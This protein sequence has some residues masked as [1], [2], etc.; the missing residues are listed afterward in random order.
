MEELDQIIL[1]ILRQI[2]CNFPEDIDTIS[3]FQSEHFVFA[4]SVALRT[5]NAAYKLPKK[6]PDA[7]A[8]RFRICT[9]MANAIQQLGYTGEIG[10]ETFLYPNEKDMRALMSF[11]VNK[12]PKVEEEH[13]EEM[14]GQSAMVTKKIVASLQG[15][16]SQHWKPFSV[17]KTQVHYHA[18]P[19][20][21]PVKTTNTDTQHYFKHYLPVINVQV[22]HNNQY[23]P[24]I[25]QTH[26]AEVSLINERQA[27]WDQEGVEGRSKEAILARKQMLAKKIAE[28]ISDAAKKAASDLAASAAFGGAASAATSLGYSNDPSRSMADILNS[29]FTSDA[30][31]RSEDSTMFSRRADF[32]QDKGDAVAHVV[33][34]DPAGGT[35]TVT[36]I[37]AEGDSIRA[38]QEE[39]QDA[40]RQKREEE[41][42]A[43][44]QQIKNSLDAISNL[45]SEMEKFKQ[46]E[47]ANVDRK[48]QLQESNAAAET[49]YKLKKQTLDL[50]PDAEKNVAALTQLVASSKQRLTDLQKQWE[51]VK[52]PYLEQFNDKKQI[53]ANRKEECRLKLDQIK[54]M[55]E[56]MKDMIT[57]LR[58]KDETFKQVVE[59]LNKLPKSVN[60]QVYVK[61]I[62]D[63]VKN[64]E[65]QKVDI[66]K[67]LADVRDVQKEINNVTEASKRSFALADD[68]IFKSAQTTKD[69]TATQGYKNLVQLRDKFDQLITVVETTGSTRNE[70][71]DHE[72]KIETL[73]ERNTNLNM[74]RVQ[75]DLDSVRA[76]NQALAKKLGLKKY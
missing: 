42:A 32:S 76:E 53:L 74:E 45:K 18:V 44:Q 51:E 33:K 50:L 67:I 1:P 75:S 19:L 63:I 22:K 30:S 65:R 39:D 20:S 24:S 23:M 59:E 43:L 56:D 73:Q 64:L 70:I 47:S 72:S 69:P 58:E 66:K 52:A 9:D 71:R 55:R 4:C 29:I 68:L 2:G 5:I 37:V 34:V 40:I 14:L 6:L 61:R 8:A 10:Y 35:E 49:E 26:V 62:M 7:K 36:Q 21:T 15:W 27:Q 41:V 54:R 28:S 17:P 46:Q 13:V 38:V 48:K 16:T 60:R 3:K 11:L 25:L 57:Q 12:L 31:S